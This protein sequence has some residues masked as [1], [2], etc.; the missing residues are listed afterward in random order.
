MKNL[1]AVFWLIL[2]FSFS[3]FSQEIY[4]LSYNFEQGKIYRYQDVIKSKTTQE[5]MGQEIR[6]DTK[7]EMMHKI[8]VDSVLENGNYLITISFDSIRAQIISK[9]MDTV[10]SLKEIPA[11][12]KKIEVDKFGNIVNKEGRDKIVIGGQLADEILQNKIELHILSDKELKI[13][14]KWE[15]TVYDTT[16]IMG[17]LIVTKAKNKYKLI[18]KENKFD[19]DCLKI[20]YETEAES[21]GN[22]KM[23][24]EQVYFESSVDVEGILY[25]DLSSKLIIYEEADV[26]DNTSLATSGPRAMIIPITQKSSFTRKLVQ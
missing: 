22:I 21:E 24:G 12:R 25:Y 13:G 17:T 2:L 14:D 1:Y 11:K 7:A 8:I 10:L 9:Q 23:Q 16:D 6:V 3:V 18:K 26:T 5:V 20:E 19:K 4:K 15:T